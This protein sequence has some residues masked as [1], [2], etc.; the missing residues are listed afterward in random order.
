MHGEADELPG[1]MAGDLYVRVK[2]QP[3][4]T[5]RRTGADLVL[6]KE[7]TLKEALTGTSFEINYFEGKKFTVATYPTEILI[8]GAIKS[9]KEKGMPFFKDSMGHGHIFIHFNVKFPKKGEIKETDFEI[10]QKILP[11]PNIILKDLKNPEYLEDFNENDT[12]PNPEGGKNKDY[13]EDEELRGGGTRV[14]CGQ[15]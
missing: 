15:Q 12:N 4:K 10:L 14:Q 13:D 1:I 8:P 6:E 2:I 5:F 3:H 11:G 7:V 9:L